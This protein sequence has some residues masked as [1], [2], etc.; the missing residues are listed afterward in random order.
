MSKCRDDSRTASDKTAVDKKVILSNRFHPLESV[1]P[2]DSFVECAQHLSEICGIDPATVV[3]KIPSADPASVEAITVEKFLEA[4]DRCLQINRFFTLGKTEGVTQE[5][6]LEVAAKLYPQV[7]LTTSDQFGEIGS[8]PS[9][10]DIDELPL[11]DDTKLVLNTAVEFLNQIFD[12]PFEKSNCIYFG[13]GSAQ[14]VDTKSPQP[15][16]KTLSNW[17]VPNSRFDP[18]EFWEDETALY[19]LSKT[20][21][22][23]VQPDIICQVPKNSKTNRT[24]GIGSVSGIAAQHIVE[25]YVRACLNK[26][27][28]DLNT[29]S[30]THRQLA[31]YGS[32]GAIDL[33]TLDLSMASDSISL[34]LTAALLNST[35][36]NE[37]CRRL[38]YKLL[39]C[40]AD[41]YTLNGETRVYHKLGPMG[42]ASI[43]GTESALF[44][45]LIIG[46]QRFCLTCCCT[47]EE[48][49]EYVQSLERHFDA[50]GLNKALLKGSSY[51]DDMILFILASLLESQQIQFWIQQLLEEI[52]LK[53][54]LEK[55]F[56]TGDFRESCGADYERGR[57]VRGFYHHRRDVTLRDVI[58]CINFFVI[59]G[60]MRLA[61]ILREC[62][63]FDS[64]Y[65]EAGLQ[66]IVWELDELGYYDRQRVDR[67]FN[68]LHEIAIPEDLICD[69]DL[70]WGKGRKITYVD[71]DVSAKVRSKFERRQIIAKTLLN[72]D[73]VQD[74]LMFSYGLQVDEPD[75]L[76]DRRFARI[77][78]IV[79]HLFVT[80]KDDVRDLL[81]AKCRDKLERV[82]F[83]N[84][85]ARTFYKLENENLTRAWPAHLCYAVY[86]GEINVED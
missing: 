16:V 74:I 68:F 58:R 48:A 85:M 38:Y 57:L 25:S 64:L 12:V 14:V 30:D 36:S 45:A 19:V 31:Y 15:S 9:P 69:W 78:R 86:G 60:K 6:A 50:L 54:N 82:F 53:L 7:N 8:N 21:G 80:A 24:I 73:Y 1:M 55:S 65:R 43:F 72:D 34:G 84:T 40:R 49:R 79:A 35:H 13:P 46:V 42:N 3:K 11:N 56:F 47:A 81:I 18:F 5:E 59:R 4:E 17:G 71:K 41:S 52:G 76:D 26:H 32:I 10:I 2:L 29:L 22:A 37:H 67:A 44:T 75:L 62:P 66:R 61:E 70:G 39:L 63:A 83:K 20:I 77:M 33:A 23:P 27:G 51:G 28:I